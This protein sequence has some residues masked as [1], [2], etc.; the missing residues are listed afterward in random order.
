VERYFEFEEGNSSK[1]WSIATEGVRQTVRYGKIGAKESGSFGD[2][3]A[4]LCLSRGQA[5]ALWQC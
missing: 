5:K 1:V 2:G 4:Y 3:L